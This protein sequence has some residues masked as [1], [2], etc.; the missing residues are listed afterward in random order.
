[1]ANMYIPLF[2]GFHTCQVVVWDFFHQQ[3]VV[4][5]KSSAINCHQN[6]S[7]CPSDDMSWKMFMP[8]E[9]KINTSPSFGPEHFRY[10]CHLWRYPTYKWSFESL[11]I[12]MEA[13]SASNG[14]QRGWAAGSKKILNPLKD[15]IFSGVFHGEKTRATD[16]IITGCLI[17]ILLM[18][19]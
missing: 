16:S 13:D 7:K 6:S 10:V 2:T 18:M 15:V 17:G 5:H 1:M 8:E 4:I 12:W 3:Y 14:T 11:Q 19:V 9:E